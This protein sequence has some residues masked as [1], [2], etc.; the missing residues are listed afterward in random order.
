MRGPSSP[1]LPYTEFGLKLRSKCGS[2]LRRVARPLPFLFGLTRGNYI[3]RAG[4]WAAVWQYADSSSDVLCLRCVSNTLAICTFRNDDMMDAIY[5]KFDGSARTDTVGANGSDIV[6]WFDE[7]IA[8][9]FAGPTRRCR[10][11]RL[12]HGVRLRK[13]WC[14]VEC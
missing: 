5:G 6:A 1:D 11:R 7:I 14:Q 13:R 10:S 2:S 12:A 9:Y 3:G 8:I 4:R